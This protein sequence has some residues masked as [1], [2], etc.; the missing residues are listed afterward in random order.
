MSSKI[1]INPFKPRKILVTHNGSFHADDVFACATLELYLR[2]Q[3]RGSRVIRSREER[4]FKRGDFVF[5][6]GGIYDVD[7]N[8]F[9]HHQKGG[10]GERPNGVPYASFGLVWKKFGA[11]LSGDQATADEIDKYLVQPIDAHDNGVDVY[12]RVVEH[13]DPVTFQD[14]AGIFHPTEGSEPH[15][16]DNAFREMVNFAK[17]ILVRVIAQTK[18]QQSVNSYMRERYDRISQKDVIIVDRH[19]GRHAV[20]VGALAL[21]EALYIVYP[22]RKGEWH[23]TAAR[24]SMSSTKNRKPLP[25]EWGGKRDAELQKVSGVTDA[26]FCHNM[27]FLAGADSR[28]GAIALA[29]KALGS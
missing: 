14:I 22:S 20:T 10:A 24:D 1:V 18:E 6:V 26:T 4:D 13:L 25:A 2:A 19:V 17:K 16:F 23:V 29:K 12:K 7:K 11:E 21:P 8:R 5:D 27:L 15:D 9:D 3:G 28:D